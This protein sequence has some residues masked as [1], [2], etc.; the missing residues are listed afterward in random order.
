VV[1][2]KEDLTDAVPAEAI[3]LAM[4][5]DLGEHRFSGR[6]LVR[7]LVGDQRPPK[8][9]QRLES[10]FWFGRLRFIGKDGACAALESLVQRGWAEVVTVTHEARVYR[11]LHITDEGR[12]HA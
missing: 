9:S 5:A 7:S 6:S 12:K 10:S 4:L 3:C 1:L 8:L 11:T 2:K